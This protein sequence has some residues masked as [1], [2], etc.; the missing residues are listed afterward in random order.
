MRARARARNTARAKTCAPRSVRR[1][2]ARGGRSRPG[3][4]T[5]SG[6]NCEK[7]YFACD[8]EEEIVTPAGPAAI[9]ADAQQAAQGPQCGFLPPSSACFVPLSSE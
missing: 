4:W 1:Q 3:G 2:R 6:G 9:E 7:T 8:G 5:P